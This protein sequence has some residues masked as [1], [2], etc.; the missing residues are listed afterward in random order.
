MELAKLYNGGHKIINDLQN[1]KN[2]TDFLNK[3]NIKIIGIITVLLILY[4]FKKY[5]FIG[6]VMFLIYMFLNSYYDSTGIVSKVSNTIN[7]FRGMGGGNITQ[8]LFNFIP[9]RGSLADNG[10]DEDGGDG[11]D[12]GDDLNERRTARREARIAARQEARKEE[13]KE[14]RRLEK[15]GLR[16]EARKLERQYQR[17]I[18][19]QER[20]E[21]R[22]FERQEARQEARREVRILERKGLRQEARKLERQFERQESRRLDRLWGAEPMFGNRNFWAD[23]VYQVGGS[24]EQYDLILELIDPEEA[25]QMF[26]EIQEE[27]EKTRRQAARQAARQAERQA[28]RQAA[29]QTDLQPVEPPE[30]TENFT[31]PNNFT[32]LPIY[33]NSIDTNPF[34]PYNVY[35]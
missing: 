4:S 3:E 24:Q 8:T 31:N 18:E 11:D 26:N 9:G 15:K 30:S 16:Q 32:N 35:P 27:I 6:V 1:K 19:K 23:L 22:Q 21:D 2:G 13:R 14:I 33:R 25:E 29:R 12:N 5:I 20:Q 34:T 17:E 28:E 7:R 10:G